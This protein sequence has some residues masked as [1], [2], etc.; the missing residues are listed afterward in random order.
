[1]DPFARPAIAIAC[2]EAIPVQ[3][4]GNEVVIGNQHKLA[5]RGDHVDRGAVALTATASGQAHLAV[6]AADPMDNEHDLRRLLVDIGDD[7]V[8][9]RR[10]MRFFSR[11][12]VEG[13][14]HTLFRSAASV[15]NDARSAAG[16]GGVGVW[17]GIFPP[18]SAH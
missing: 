16:A 6:D 17:G 12:S 7:L 13:A 5:D 14:V 8:N 15:T 4:A 10:T 1:R 11:A 18:T 2:D 9:D 3:D